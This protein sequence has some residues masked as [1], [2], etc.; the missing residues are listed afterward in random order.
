MLSARDLLGTSLTTQS[1]RE[2]NDNCT[3]RL[4]PDGVRGCYVTLIGSGAAGG[5]G[6]Q[7]GS[8]GW[9]G[10]GGARV[11][12]TWIPRPLLGDTYS[13]SVGR[14]GVT[15]GESGTS[16]VFTSGSITLTAGSGTGQGVGG[17]ATAV[18][19]NA[20]TYSGS[21]QNTDELVG[22][23]GAG[24]G[25]GGAWGGAYT[26]TPLPGATGGSSLSVYGGATNVAATNAVSGNGG[27]GGGGGYGE[28]A[29]V[30]HAGMSGGLYGGGGGGGGISVNYNAAGGPGAD[31]YALVE[32]VGAQPLSPKQVKAAGMSFNATG[33]IIGTWDDV[34]A[35]VPT[36]Y[37]DGYVSELSSDKAF[38]MVP[39]DM[40][41]R[42][43]GS[44]TYA[45]AAGT[46]AKNDPGPYTAA[47]IFDGSGNAL[48]SAA[49]YGG[50]GTL[51]MSYRGFLYAGQLY[52]VKIYESN[53]AGYGT[54]SSGTLTMTPLF[55]E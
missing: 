53:V 22:N 51:T 34:H 23:A 54:Y 47:A 48:A 42:L 41:A 21:N 30:P 32:W 10:G 43:D 16:T 52:T 55:R 5:N 13:V 12:R 28:W 20:V 1:F 49:A 46:G 15:S 11:N 40:I 38:L 6:R 37:S 35:W 27:A 36:V 18:G 39:T 50:S 14:G 44:I 25:F 26:T 17:V 29:G 3:Y 31:G 4:V 9:G 7:N 24:G 33:G 8:V 2:E 45:G 19:I